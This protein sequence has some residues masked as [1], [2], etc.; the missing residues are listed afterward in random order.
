M[1]SE[2]R[3]HTVRFCFRDVCYDLHHTDPSLHTLVHNMYVRRK[4]RIRTIL[5][6]LRKSLALLR[7]PSDRAECFALTSPTCSGFLHASS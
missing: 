4:V 7:K 6:F 1:G 5:G 2:L 3:M